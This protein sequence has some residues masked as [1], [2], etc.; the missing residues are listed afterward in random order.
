MNFAAK[1]RVQNLQNEFRMYS[2]QWIPLTTQVDPFLRIHFS[3]KLDEKLSGGGILH[4]TTGSK[5]SAEVQKRLL[6]FA[7]KQ[8]VVYFAFNYILSKCSCGEITPSDI[9]ICPK[10][11]SGN[12]EHFTRVVGFLTPV[13]SWNAERRNEFHYRVRYDIDA[14]QKE[15]A[16]LSGKENEEKTVTILQ[17]A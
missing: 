12:I 16:E 15:L 1:D 3:G 9:H 5:V 14:R 6:C 13:K 17:V 4:I 7:A 8:G 10:C 2:N 11:G